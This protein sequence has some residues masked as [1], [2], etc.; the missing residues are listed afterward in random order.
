MPRF[1]IIVCACLC[2][3]GITSA[4]ED[5]TTIDKSLIPASANEISKFVPKGWKIEEQLKS[6]FDADGRPDYVLK[7]I[8]DKPAKDKDDNPIDRARALVIVMQN[9]NGGYRRAAVADKLLQC[10][11]CGGAFYGVVEAPANITIEKGVIVVEQD[12]GSR[13]VSD[14][15]FRFRYEPETQKF[16]LIG[17]D[18]INNDRA[19]RNGV[20]ES[21]N[22]L[23]GVRI[24]QRT[25][26]RETTSRTQIPKTKIYMDDVD[27]EKLEEDAVNRLGL[28]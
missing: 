7:L 18:Y 1:S 20:N 10:T 17:F 9:E 27:Y 16:L 2:F 12:H 14:M 4:Q 8:E 3:V 26:K 22:Y 19:E 21:T 11:Q 13:W 28:G 25:G 23:T 24:V 5:R 15:T 6:D